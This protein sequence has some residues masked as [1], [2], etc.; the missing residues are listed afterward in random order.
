MVL[1]ALAVIASLKPT[2]YRLAEDVC[3]VACGEDQITVIENEI[4]CAGCLQQI[5]VL[6]GCVDDYA[7]R[8]GCSWMMPGICSTHD[9]DV[10]VAGMA[11]PATPQAALSLLN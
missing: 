9:G 6:C 1:F 2:L 7:C 8:D 11:I 4:V 5:C 3:C 10:R